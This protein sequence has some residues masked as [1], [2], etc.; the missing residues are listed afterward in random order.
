[1]KSTMTVAEAGG[2]YTVDITDVPPEAPPGGGDGAPAFGPMK[3][4]ISDVAVDGSVLT[5]KRHLASDQFNIDLT[6]KATVTGNT[7]TAT[8][9]SEYGD[10]PVTGTRAQ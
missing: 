5:F 10:T 2:A 3:S 8:A 9:G 4:T 6:Y 7:L 1:M